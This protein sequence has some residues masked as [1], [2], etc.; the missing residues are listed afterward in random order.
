MTS[1]EHGSTH[2]Y[3]WQAYVKKYSTNTFITQ[4]YQATVAETCI[5]L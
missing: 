4:K 2:N 1:I 3:A 5:I